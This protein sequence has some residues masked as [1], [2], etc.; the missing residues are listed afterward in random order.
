MFGLHAVAGALSNRI[1]LFV[2][3]NWVCAIMLPKRPLDDILIIFSFLFFRNSS[4][5][6]WLKLMFIAWLSV[7]TA[8]AFVSQT[9]PLSIIHVAQVYIAFAMR[10]TFQRQP[11]KWRM[12]WWS[13]CAS[14]FIID[15]TFSLCSVLCVAWHLFFGFHSLIA[16]NVRCVHLLY[17]G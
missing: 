10:Y 4:H 14:F 5:T 12:N 9:I 15:F 13:L 8:N 2:C 6:R 1:S 7:A 11:R 16:G 3:I 17:G